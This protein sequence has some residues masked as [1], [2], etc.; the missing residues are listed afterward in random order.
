MI[1]K[2]YLI[3][4]L[5]L[6]SAVSCNTGTHGKKA[7]ASITG[8][9]QPA[10]ASAALQNTT[11]ATVTEKSGPHIDTVSLTLF[12]K[13]FQRNISESNRDSIINILEFPVR[14]IYP[15]LFR[16]AFDCD[17]ARFI[18]HEKQYADVSINREDAE[19][20]YDFIFSDALKTFIR[21]TTVTDL[22]GCWYKAPFMRRCWYMA[23][24]G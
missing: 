11:A 4:L 23:L 2:I 18:K 13:G 9:E 21:Q 17:T 19:E 12:W 16:F 14:A 22:P 3:L 10:G 6:L 15:V 20:Y 1:M 7:P 24:P 5:A 8:N